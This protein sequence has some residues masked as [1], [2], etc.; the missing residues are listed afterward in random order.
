MASEFTEFGQCRSRMLQVKT[1]LRQEIR[2]PGCSLEL[3]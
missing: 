2:E 1:A 3:S